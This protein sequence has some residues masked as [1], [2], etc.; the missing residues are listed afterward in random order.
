[1]SQEEVMRFLKDV[2]Q[3]HDLRTSLE[4]AA[5]PQAFIQMVHQLGYQF[6]AGELEEVAHEQSQGIITRRPTGVWH[7]LRTVNWIDR[8]QTTHSL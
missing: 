3:D 7:W 1:M 4:E 8:S 2:N 5:D 6:E